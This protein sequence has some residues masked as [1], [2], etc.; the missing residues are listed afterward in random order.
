[1]PFIRWQWY[2]NKTK[3]TKNTQINKCE[4]RENAVITETDWAH[5][6]SPWMMQRARLTCT[7]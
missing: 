7:V 5:V 6:Y 2:Y 1:M 4:S 3:H